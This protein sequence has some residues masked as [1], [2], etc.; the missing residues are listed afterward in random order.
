MNSLGNHTK[1]KNLRLLRKVNW[2]ES[3]FN[4]NC[5]GGSFPQLEVFEMKNLRVGK[6]KLGNGAMPRLQ[7]VIIHNCEGDFSFKSYK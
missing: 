2:S 7:S 3:C 5:V 4:L 1:L 6:W